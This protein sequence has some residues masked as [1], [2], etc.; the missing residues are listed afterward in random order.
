M[1]RP[2]ISLLRPCSGSWRNCRPSPSSE[3]FIGGAPINKKI[4]KSVLRIWVV[5]PG[6]WILIYPSRI[7]DPG[8]KNSNNKDLLSYLFCS[9]KFHKIENYF[10]F[11]MLK[12]RIWASFQR[13]IEL[14]TQKFVTKFSKI[15]VW[16]PG[17]GSRGQK[18]TGSRIRIR[19]TE[20]IVDLLPHKQS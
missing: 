9:Y 18:G 14:Y 3:T 13:I 16:D 15:W 10:I 1:C 7:P 8:S 19:N 6:S 11:E 5:Y 20:I 17:S 4:I 12:K 2:R